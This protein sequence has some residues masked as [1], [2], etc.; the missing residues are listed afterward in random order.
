MIKK[1]FLLL[2]V[3]V[4]LLAVV[5]L[6]L[7]F[8]VRTVC[9]GDVCPQNGGTYLFY[10]HAYSKEECAS[11]GDTP[12]VGVGWSEVYAGCSPSNTLSRWVDMLNK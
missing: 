2:I 3:L 6:L 10:K 11:R 12:I 4:G 9:F 5:Y 7:P 8:R 1:L